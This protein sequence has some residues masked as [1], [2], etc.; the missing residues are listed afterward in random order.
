[1]DG[2]KALSFSRER[3]SFSDG[4]HQRG[5]DQ[6]EVIKGIINKC[7]S[8]AILSGFSDILAEVSS[9]VQTSLTTEEL[10]ALV[11]MELDN[12]GN[13]EMFSYE[14][15]TKGSREYCYSYSGKS[16][17]VGYLVDDSLNQAK[18]AIDRLMNGERI[19]QEDVAQ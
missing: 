18:A 9:Q 5:R 7:T 4:D 11:K 8:P 12:P 1:M 10:Y 16:L 17:Y 13:W 19:T 15:K 6:M 2:E 14:T 3:Y